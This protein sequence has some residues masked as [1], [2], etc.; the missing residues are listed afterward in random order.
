MQRCQKCSKM[1]AG[2]N[3]HDSSLSKIAWWPVEDQI[4]G[5]SACVSRAKIQWSSLQG[6]SIP[7]SMYHLRK[8]IRSLQPSSSAQSAFI[9]G[10]WDNRGF[11]DASVRGEEHNP[12][13]KTTAGKAGGAARPDE[14]IRVFPNQHKK[15]MRSELIHWVLIVSVS[16]KIVLQF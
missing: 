5:S 16:C 10:S 14:S 7:W 15:E 4:R 2:W 3:C 1:C 12:E 11:T 13:S 9:V 6:R 8:C